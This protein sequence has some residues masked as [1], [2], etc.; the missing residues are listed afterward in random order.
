MQV[1]IQHSIRS[2]LA[3]KTGL[4]V[5][6][7]FDGVKYPDE[8]PFLT[9]EQLPNS[10]SVISKRREAIQ[11]IY[12]FQVGVFASSNFERG[13]L[14]EKVKRIFMF[15]QIEL[16]SAE[17][18]GK[19]LG[20]FDALVTDET[21]MSAEDL[22]DKTTYHRLYFDVEVNMTYGKQGGK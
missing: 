8:K 9:I 14:Q 11:T 21:P 10:I 16:L 2:H 4:S 3:E 13:V 19:S 7:I 1:D 15:D 22:S 20:F 6:W 17:E 12:R 5:V 18:P